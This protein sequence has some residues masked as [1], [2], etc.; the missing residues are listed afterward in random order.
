MEAQKFHQQFFGHLKITD[1]GRNMQCAYTSDVEEISTFKT[2][3]VLKS[4]LHM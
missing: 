3:E 2:F 4:K 1:V